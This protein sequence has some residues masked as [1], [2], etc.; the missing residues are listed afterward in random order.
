MADADFNLQSLPSN[1][2]KVYK[3]VMSDRGPSLNDCAQKQA[4]AFGQQVKQAAPND[5]LNNSI[6]CGDVTFHNPLCDSRFKKV[7]VTVIYSQEPHLGEPPDPS[8]KAKLQSSQSSNQSEIKIVQVWSMAVEKD[9]NSVDNSHQYPNLVEQVS[10]II[11]AD[12]SSN[13]EASQTV[14]TQES[15]VHSEA[16]AIRKTW[17]GRARINKYVSNSS[18]KTTDKKATYL[19]RQRECQ[20]ERKRELRKDPAYAERERERKRERQR[21]LRKDPDYAERERERKREWRRKRCQ[22]DPDYAERQ[23]KHKRECQRKRYQT[24]PDYA[25]RERERQR[26][27]QR[28]RYQTDPD[29]AK[30]LRERLRERYQTDPDYAKRERE[31]KREWRRKRYQADPDYAKRQREHQRERQRERYQTDPDY[32]ERQ[33]ERQRER[34]KQRCQSVNSAE[35]T[36]SSSKN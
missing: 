23:K 14:Q 15:L 17:E 25:E 27:R 22:T 19:E 30:R 36:Q 4:I 21:E 7:P 33:R 16:V 12:N 10:Q 13:I 18:K 29:Y 3:A 32:A 8:V 34:K 5:H 35:T 24:D 20:R 9:S 26:E 6:P 28:E 31:R 2:Q 1:F 11:S